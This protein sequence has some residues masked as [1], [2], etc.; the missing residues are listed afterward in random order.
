MCCTQE[1]LGI[2]HLLRLD[3]YSDHA[4][5]ETWDYSAWIRVYSAYLDERLEAWR[6]LKFDPEHEVA[7]ARRFCYFLSCCA[8]LCLTRKPGAR[9]GG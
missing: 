9:G 8:L 5:R 7:G 2:H 3:N 6:L 4:T 1:R